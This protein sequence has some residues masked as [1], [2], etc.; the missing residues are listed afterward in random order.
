MKGCLRTIVPA[1]GTPH[2]P[3]GKWRAGRRAARGP[4]GVPAASPPP[5]CAKASGQAPLPSPHGGG[6]GSVQD[7]QC[8]AHPPGH[9][10]PAWG[11]SARLAFATSESL[12]SRGGGTRRT[13]ATRRMAAIPPHRPSPL[14]G[15]G[16][17]AKPRRMRGCFRTIVPSDGT[18]H[19]PSGKW[20]A[21][22]RAARGPF[23]VPAASPP[24]QLRQGLRPGFATLPTRGRD[25]FRARL[26]E[27]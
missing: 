26:P 12:A 13:L 27:Q 9:P 21:G 15:E 17:S 8:R 20:R 19:P 22:R 4:F 5:S 3:S 14:E 10:S 24:T 11:G 7:R 1:D 2:P 23:G 16:G 25:G 6:M 18:P